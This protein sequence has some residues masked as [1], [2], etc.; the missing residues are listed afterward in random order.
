[1]KRPLG[2]IAAGATALAATILMTA[3]SASAQPDPG[4]GDYDHVANYDGARVYFKEHGDVVTLCDTAANGHAAEAYVWDDLPG[5]HVYTL[6]VH[7]GKGTCKTHRASD[8][9]K[10]NLLENRY[11][12]F[13]IDG[14]GDGTWYIFKWYNDH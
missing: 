6:E 10:Y 1:M 7:S 2:R 12:F 13:K 8:G 14:D 5:D 4:G 11:A 9:S 3:G